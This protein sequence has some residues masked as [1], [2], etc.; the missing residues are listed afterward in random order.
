MDVILL[1][2]F[3]IIILCSY[4]VLSKPRG[5]PPGPWSLP[6]LGSYFF[7]QK[8]KE[9]REHLSFS[10]AAKK[11]G[12]IFHL[13]IGS[14]LIVVLQGYEAIHQA[15]VKQGDVF[16]DRAGFLPGFHIK[17]KDGKG[18]SFQDYNNHC[19]VLRK[20]TLQTFRNI[21]TI[22]ETIL[23]EVD[24]ATRV[25]TGTG[26]NPIQIAPILQKMIANVT[27]KFLLGKRYDFDDAEFSEI[28]EMSNVLTNTRVGLTSSA[29]YFHPWVARFFSGQD[30]K[31]NR[32]RLQCIDK[33]RL[34]IKTNYR[35]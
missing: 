4:I 32:Y 16:S 8:V 11:Y 2:I 26:D 9:K 15:L 7:L 31:K 22:Q 33:I 12:N 3:A 23:T 20:F 10:E 30:N 28:N 17:P 34:P 24:A 18:V 13:R 25:L 19:K 29:L 35:A 6:L 21:E 27:N 1:L 14:Y 5:L